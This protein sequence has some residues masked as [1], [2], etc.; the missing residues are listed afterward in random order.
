MRIDR[1][2]KRS[3]CCMCLTKPD[4]W[5]RLQVE[6]IELVWVFKFCSLL[7]LVFKLAPRLAP[8]LAQRGRLCHCVVFFSWKKMSKHTLDNRRLTVY[9][10]VRQ[11]IT[12]EVLST[13]DTCGVKK[14]TFPSLPTKWKIML[15]EFILILFLCSHMLRCYLGS[16]QHPRGPPRVSV[17]FRNCRVVSSKG[18][19]SHRTK[20]NSCPTPKW[21]K[22]I[23]NLS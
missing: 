14:R 9:T 5:P 19:L 12:I 3:H 15:F 8:R 1:L 18:R 22:Q 10:L 6:V 20:E 13:N 4:K 2:W 16:L 11:N 21:I 23:I 7:V 17:P